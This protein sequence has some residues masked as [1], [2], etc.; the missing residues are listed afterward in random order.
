MEN[1]LLERE[2]IQEEGFDA[3]TK[4]LEAI[5]PETELSEEIAEESIEETE[6]SVQEP[7]E[8]A[9][10]STEEPAPEETTE[11]APTEDTAPIANETEEDPF[12][13]Q[14]KKEKTLKD[15]LNSISL[16]LLLVAFAIPVSIIAYILIKFFLM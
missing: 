10:E 3:P 11:V 7:I 1:E 5:E 16:L 2:E 13:T 4:E 9:E 8:V 12:A 14:P 15:R 6:K